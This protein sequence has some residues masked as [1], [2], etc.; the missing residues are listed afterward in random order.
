MKY[1][2]S[3]STGSTPFPRLNPMRYNDNYSC[4]LGHSKGCIRRQ[5]YH[6]NYNGLNSSNSNKPSHNKEKQ[7]KGKKYT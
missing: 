5:F 2:E 3:W 1:H 4:G 7:E 6:R